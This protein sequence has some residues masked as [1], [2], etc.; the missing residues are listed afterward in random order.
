MKTRK[1]RLELI[2]S[3]LKSKARKC[4]IYLNET[5]WWHIREQ[6]WLR[7]ELRGTIREIRY[8]QTQLTLEIAANP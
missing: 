6:I 1:E 4:R 5:P 3:A 8:A 7:L 2:I